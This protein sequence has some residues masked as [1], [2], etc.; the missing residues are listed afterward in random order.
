MSNRP[1]AADRL[2]TNPGFAVGLLRRSLNGQALQGAALLLLAGHAIWK[3][4]RPDRTR[5]F[6]SGPDHDPYPMTPLDRPVMDNPALLE[7]TAETVV[8]AYSLDFVRY[9]QQSEA[10]KARFELRAWN[11]WAQSFMDAGNLR[12]LVEAKMV[13]RAVPRSAPVVKHEGVVQGR[14]VW[15]VEFPMVLSYENTNG[16]PDEVLLMKALVVR[17]DDPKHRRGI[18]VAQ[19]VASP[20]IEPRTPRAVS[21]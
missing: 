12:K 13:T 18:V 21:R 15:D 2:L 11:T 20:W 7:W 17:S 6:A 4:T 19:L 1:A 10:A 5:Y 8:A 3:E 9:R 16:A 14:Y